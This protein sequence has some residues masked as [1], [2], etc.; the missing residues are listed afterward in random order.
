[1][2][3]IIYVWKNIK[4]YIFARNIQIGC[5]TFFNLLWSNQLYIF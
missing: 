3:E 4:A 2:N 5:E 1:M